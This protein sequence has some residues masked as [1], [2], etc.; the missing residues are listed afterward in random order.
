MYGRIVDETMEDIPQGVLLKLRSVLCHFK[1]I[2]NTGAWDYICSSILRNAEE[3]VKRGQLCVFYIIWKLH[4][5][6]SANSLRCLP[7]AAVI[8]YVT[9]QAYHFLHC[10]LQGDI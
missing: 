3:E 9:G 1:G 7:I 8:N 4:K 5:A 10:Q 6:P 2:G